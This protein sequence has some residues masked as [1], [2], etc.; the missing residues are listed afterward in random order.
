MARIEKTIKVIIDVD[1]S[2]NRVK[3][4]AFELD[5]ELL[6]QLLLFDYCEE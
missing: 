4:V 2:N 3:E 1:E 6:E 5:D